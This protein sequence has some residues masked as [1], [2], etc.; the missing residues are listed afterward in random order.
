[1]RFPLKDLFSCLTPFVHRR[2]TFSEAENY[3]PARSTVG[4]SG[5]LASE[6]GG[7]Y[8]RD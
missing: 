5:L 1:M 2:E 8:Q 6:A 4:I 3:P 7:S